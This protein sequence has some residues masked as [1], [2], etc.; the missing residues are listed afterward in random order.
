MWLTKISIQNP[1][2]S[3]VLMAL[4]VVVGLFSMSRLPVEK[5]PEVRFPLVVIS[6]AY[7][8]AAP[9]V[10]ESEVTRTIEEAV[11]TV[12]GVE[13]LRSYSFEGSSVVIIEFN[14][15]M[16]PDEALQNVREKI[17]P[18]QGKFRR[19][20]S[21]PAISQMNPMDQAI[22]TI[23]IAA[24]ASTPLRELST[25][26]EQVLRKEMQ[27]IPG[28]GDATL[29]GGIERQVRIDIAPEKLDAYA[30]DI[31][32]VS[33]LI[34]A[35]NQNF[36]SGKLEELNQDIR[37]R[38]EG[39]LKTIDDFKNLPI[40]WQDNSMIL[41]GDIAEVKD[42]QAE[43]SS[44]ALVN[45]KRAVTIEIK[46]TR[47][48]NIVQLSQ[49]VRDKLATLKPSFPKNLD[50][51]ILSDNAEEVQRSL[52]T[53][54]NT[55]VEGTILT[56]L[57]VFLFLGS[58]RSTII[59]GLTLP[60]ALIGTLFAIFVAG[61]TLNVMTLLALTLSIGLLI[62]DAIV[63]R[64]N[65]VRH[66][67]LGKNHFQA[68]LDGTNEIGIAVL[69]TTLTVVAVFL[70]VGFMDGIIGKFFQQFGLT[71]V[72]AVLI[73]LAV[74]FSLDP[75][76]SSIWAD[77]PPTET[78][79]M[80]LFWRFLAA[81]NH[82][83]DDIAQAY[84]RAIVWVLAHRIKTLLVA[85]A[86]LLASFALVPIIGAEFLP[87]G[88]SGRFQLSFRTQAGTSL[89]Y[90]EAKAREIEQV[91]Q[92]T[93]PD[94]K[95]IYTNI[96]G[97]FAASSNQAT[98]NVQRDPQSIKHHATANYFAP[99]RAQI[100]AIAGVELQAL[101][102]SGSPG[103]DQKPVRLGIRG[104]DFAVL[105]R[106]SHDLKR[107]LANI[108]EIKDIEISLDKD[109]PALAISLNREA[110]SSLGISLDTLGSTLST[111]VAG[112]TI[113]TWEAPDGENY[114]VVMQLPKSLRQASILD[115]LTISG[116]QNQ[117]VP[118]ST[119]AQISPSSVPKQIER[120]NQQRE[121]SLTA[122]I[123]SPDSRAVFAKIDAILQA[124]PLP[125]GYLFAQDGDQK[126]MQESFSYAMQALALGVIF[127][128]LI[129]VAQFRS[130]TQP[131]AIMM[132]LPMAFV[133]V[134]L[135]LLLWGST[136]N[137]FSII[138][139]IMLMGLVAKNGILLIDFVNQ[140]RRAGMS[141]HDALCEAGRIRL[142]PILM[143][144]AAMIFGMLPLALSQAEGSELN[145][146]MAQAV[147]GGMI[148]STLLTLFVVPV[149]YSYLDSWAEN[150]IQKLKKL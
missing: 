66:A 102:I 137:M 39:K 43:F 111:L 67:H 54:R 99:L 59:T 141:Q 79:K 97:G 147:I 123:H 83:M 17:S 29:V 93:I 113:T 45:G 9:T 92:Q 85:S 12:A 132:S 128:Y 34:R 42:A 19:E 139:V 64:E 31:N 71:V 25:W 16:N 4:I 133:G 78:Q 88:D 10:V 69:A 90:T 127:I 60:I 82:K 146:P 149:V 53:V 68:A 7:P 80:R 6:T 142:R 3:T 50:V 55:L 37:L 51:N 105:S 18:I 91:L 129:L 70:P 112:S 20:I 145:A 108:P 56:V 117:R 74:S 130:F 46:A 94:I 28:V 35:A 2:F 107:E 49:K 44:L 73:S 87:A 136:L 134:F 95:H 27:N 114:D 72:V 40:S 76:L 75:M 22:M 101:S 14:L 5:F 115:I 104:S 47:G 15:S 116:G 124:Y 11:N 109:D 77:P 135:A 96:G 106:I 13:K 131:I 98:L 86:L 121:I 110:A 148:A 52:D 122:N 89:E 48:A 125:A 138:G 150:M 140:A 62:D 103:G 26:G 58:W 57:I 33:N 41:L 23:V 126:N 61:F 1:Y 120:M 30:L 63:V 65:I 21:A 118:L 24:D 32:Q 84:S 119:I 144:S 38:L 81:F 36:P 8:G 100:T 143:T